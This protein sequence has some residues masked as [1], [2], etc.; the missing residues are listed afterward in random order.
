MDLIYIVLFSVVKALYST[1]HR[2]CAFKWYNAL[3]YNLRVIVVQHE[4][5][6]V[7]NIP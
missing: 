3:K 4:T 6:T 1:C 7:F 5:T 2:L